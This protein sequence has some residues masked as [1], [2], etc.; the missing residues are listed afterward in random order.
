MKKIF[1]LTVVV[2]LI[3]FLV[4]CGDD[5]EE[6]KFHYKPEIYKHDQVITNT[7]IINDS[8]YR[9]TVEFNVVSNTDEDKLELCRKNIEKLETQLAKL[10][11]TKL[12]LKDEKKLTKKEKK[13]WENNYKDAIKSTQSWIKEM[14]TKE[15]EYLPTEE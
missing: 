6:A 4:G 12:L 5:K 11:E 13:E 1:K 7:S 2:L 8:V 3:I 15:K 9:S 14:K 10:E